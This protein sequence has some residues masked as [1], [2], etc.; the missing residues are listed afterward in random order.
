MG[1]V[2]DVISSV[3]TLTATGVALFLLWQGQRDRRELRQDRQREQAV[4]VT[5][6]CE[7]NPDSPL[8]TLGSPN[9]PAIYVR[10]TSDQ[11]VYRAFVDY[12]RPQGGVVRLD[13]GPVPPG[14]TRHQDVDVE[15]PNSPPWE[16]AALM[17]RLYFSDAAGLDWIRNAKGRLVADGPHH[18][19]S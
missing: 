5:C 7:W 19:G 6:W 4:K 16:P 10:N 13:I 14:E 2:A 18:I 12:V 1:T 3:G 15:L 9:V 17:P 11:A 8:A